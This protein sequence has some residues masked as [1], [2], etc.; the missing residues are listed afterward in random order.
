MR[1]FRK[2]S[3]FTA[4]CFILALGCHSVSLKSPNVDRA[5]ENHWQKDYTWA[6]THQTEEPAKSCE[7]FT[8]LGGDVKFPARD[9][10][11]LRAV[12]VCADQSPAIDRASFPPYLQDLAIDILLKVSSERKD[13]IMEMQLAIEKSKQKLQQSEKVRWMQLAIQRATEA[14]DQERMEEYSKR[15]Y[16]IAPR[17]N[18][19]PEV[20]QFASVAN[21]LRLARDFAKARSYYEKVIASKIYSVEDKIAA[22]KGI[23]LSYKNVR[24]N[25]EHIKTSERLIAFLRLQVKAN[26]RSRSLLTAFYDAE[27]Y[28]AR[29]VWTLGN[30]AAAR[31]ILDRVE[32]RMTD[33]KNRARVSL[34]E[35]YWIRARLAEETESADVVSKFLSLASKEKTSD[36]ELR[37]KILWYSAWNERRRK[38]LSA[39]IDYLKQMSDVA[40]SDFS[41]SR[42]LYWLGRSMVENNQIS[43]GKEMYQRLVG[44]DPLG[45]Y[46]LLAHH[47]LNIP[48]SIERAKEKAAGIAGQTPQIPLDVVT[49]KWLAALGERE[50]LTS[51]LD[52]ASAAYRTQ[53]NQ[54]DAGWV[55]IF[56]HYAQAGLYMKLYESLSTI[57]A[58]QR[59]S[60]FEHHPD[61]LFP[62]PWI[63]DARTAASQFGIQENLIYAIIRQESAF[64]VHA[65]SFAD[66]FG[67]MQLLPE[68][69]EQLSQRYNI[70]YS[71]ME[72]LYDPKT[73]MLL[74]AAHLK[75]LFDRQ[76]GHFILAVASYNA[77]ENAID[78]WMKSRFR[79][80]AQEFIEDIPYEETRA[81]VRLVIRNLTFYDLLQSKSAQIAFPDWVLK[82]DK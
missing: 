30:A 54:T 36:P 64:D 27:M 11:R 19:S 1:H 34:A 17:L 21:D 79:G 13:G 61:L 47:Q 50:A 72:D 41:R 23:R 35:L 45:Y 43:D 7:V 77:S 66:A 8:R 57:T 59:K 55:Q 26:P 39:A 51:M 38:N 63:D 22:L 78:K 67:V 44:E 4:T 28:H 49:A 9:I 82:L 40:Q 32:K 18:P 73:N 16:M 80:D 68:V 6:R 29:A 75:E 33:R 52:I 69:A 10:A 56:Q 70:P 42:A 71:N 53:K 60:I 31:Q 24:A 12:E 81:Y 2:L 20:T 14:K 48:I 62:Q 65:R 76:R 46:G 3:I 25:E 37:D 5:E 58:G 15:L 74:G